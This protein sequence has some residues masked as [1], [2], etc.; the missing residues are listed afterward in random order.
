LKSEKKSLETYSKIYHQDY[1]F[2]AEENINLLNANFTLNRLQGPVIE[3][4]C[5]NGTWTKL[6]V[7]RFGSAVVVD[8]SPTLLNKLTKEHGSKIQ[9]YECL[10]ENFQPPLLNYN[11]VLLIGALHHCQNPVTV[12]KKISSWIHPHAK[13][14][15]SVPNADSLHRRLGKAMGIISENHEIS[16]LGEDQGHRRTYNVK[17]FKKHLL[18][19]GFEIKFFKGL[20]LKPLSNAQMNTLPE[21]VFSGL[22]K[23]GHDLPVEFSATL[24]AECTKAQ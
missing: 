9:C 2:G 4:G 22:F 24:Y 7:A 1:A 23:L 10:F 13:L 18:Q 15:V 21:S 17:L 11:S 20:F 5:G 3:L 8:A 14:F 16:K 6:I 19:A 12:L